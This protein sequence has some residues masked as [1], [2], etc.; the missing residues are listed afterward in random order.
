MI[1]PNKRSSDTARG[2][3]QYRPNRRLKLIQKRSAADYRPLS[4]RGDDGHVLGRR[5]RV[6]RSA[7]GASCNITDSVYA[8]G[9]FE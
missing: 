2:P 3:T 7:S 4:L 6:L 9:A 5:P 8:Y 1:P